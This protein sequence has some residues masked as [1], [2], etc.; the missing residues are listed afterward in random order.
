M[1]SPP[2]PGV[3]LPDAGASLSLFGIARASRE[4]H[5]FVND[6]SGLARLSLDM[7]EAVLA[8]R[9]PAR[10]FAGF[11]QWSFALPVAGR[12]ARLAAVARGVWVFG[13]PD[14][15]PPAIPGLTWVALGERHAL[16][17][18][19]FLVVDAEAY[20]AALAAEDLDG[21][22]AP[23]AR[24]RFRAVW[25]CD[26]ALVGEMGERLG[27]A[28]GLAPEP[29][30]R[31]RDHAAQLAHVG[32]T[33]SGLLV[34]LQE[35]QDALARAQRLRE[36]LTGL[37]F[38]DLRNPLAVI[39]ARTELLTKLGSPTPEM[40]VRSATAIN[41][42]ARRLDEMLV[43]LLDVAGLEAG[44]LPLA[45]EAVDV[46]ALVAS[47]VDAFRAIAQVQ[48]KAI[49]AGIELS[50]GAVVRGDRDKLSRVLGA[51]LGNAL[52]YS[53]RG[54]HV[55]VRV[56]RTAAGTELAVSDDGPGIP[57]QAHDQVFQRF[58][59]AA[60]E[61][62]RPGTGLGLYF[63]RLVVEAHGGTIAVDNR[64]GRG[65]TFRFTLPLDPAG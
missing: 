19:W 41:S 17:R 39:L 18:E 4:P 21:V 3:A 8:G 62:Q 64:P 2:G 59:Q 55:E 48:D 7:E 29:A 54:G 34:R 43:T 28:L 51:L 38:H 13:R 11:Q 32:A 22:E 61:A 26:D 35:G 16:A 12:Y 37:L 24:R 27:G 42:E 60:G 36:D 52:K 40:L 25:S 33:V 14:V 23:A 10:I 56:R 49:A 31:R 65:A 47:V 58:G 15:E 50:E 63:C 46:R 20:Y 5:L 1:A 6:R 53:D 9:L 45:M 44:R 57:P 30:P